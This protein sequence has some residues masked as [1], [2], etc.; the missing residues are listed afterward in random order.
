MT[1]RYIGLMSGTSRD[2]IDAVLTESLGG[3]RMQVLDHLQ[4]EFPDDL[5][6][7]LATAAT[8]TTLRYAQ[9]GTLDAKLGDLFGQA[10]LALLEQ[11]GLPPA[12]IRAIGSHGQTV[13]HAPDRNPAFTWQIGDPF[14]IAEI[15]GI[16]TVAQ[17]R[18]RDIAAGGQG[19]PLACG[20]HAA[21]FASPDEARAVLNLGGIGNITWLAPGRAVTGFDCGPANT[22]L[23]AW[24]RC[25][26]GTAFDRNGNWARSGQPDP[27]L[28]A[29]L[30]DDPFFERPPPKSTG[31]EYF[32]PAWLRARTGEALEQ[33]RPEDIQATLVE[34]TIT[35]VRRALQA[36]DIR[37][38]A[39]LLVC[40]GGALNTYL[41]ERLQQTQT[42]TRV[43][44]T[45]GHGI[46]PQQV[47]GAAFA[48]LAARTLAG[49]TGNLP[50][51][52]GARGP[53]VLGCIIPG[54]TGR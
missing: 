46:P 25:H 1:D 12:T 53:R 13:H 44:T 2:G 9:L 18:P 10:V 31:P 50:E 20:F 42:G 14:R 21:Q 34:L 29:R 7:E 19:A 24:N 54:G 47:E 26:Q 49:H 5:A 23:D 4:L 37:P 32:S 28:L 33:A 30:L 51:V 3:G 45:T 6:A 39:R 38:P 27:H 22:L 36:V 41:M 35:S 16:D 40:G 52:T 15:T 8:T 48:W 43:E 11:T 17:F